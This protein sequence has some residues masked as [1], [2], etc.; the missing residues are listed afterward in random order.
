[1]KE[2]SRL[3]YH[4]NKIYLE[5]GYSLEKKKTNH[6]TVFSF[7]ELNVLKKLD[8]S[9]NIRLER[10][11]DLFLVGCYTGLRFSDW[12]KVNKQNI[13]SEG[14]GQLLG[15]VT[16]KT[17]VEVYI[18]GLPELMEILEK[19]DYKLPSI[20]GQKFNDYIKEVVEIALP[21][22][23]VKIT[24]SIAGKTDTKVVPKHTVTTSH[25]ARRSFATNFFE[26]GIPVSILIQIT[27][28]STEKQFF[29]YVDA[30]KK[31]LAAKFAELVAASRKITPL[32]VVK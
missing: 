9:K 10:V 8:L 12:H 16:Q 1:L 15:I 25:C 13:L 20:S 28:H 23:N 17:K 21:D 11:R 24:Q 7:S 26:M 2:T 22:S 32:S 29:E 6:R 3:G 4:S 27:G 31:K 14:N 5:S 30:D 19:Y 18:P